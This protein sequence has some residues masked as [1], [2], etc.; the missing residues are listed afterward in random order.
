MVQAKFK[1]GQLVRIVGKYV[2]PEL[3]YKTGEIK[4]VQNLDEAKIVRYIIPVNGTDR[5]FYQ[6]ELEKN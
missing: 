3:K 2:P 5:F 1:K 4:E 6:D